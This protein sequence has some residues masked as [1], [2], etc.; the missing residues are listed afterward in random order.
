MNGQN[1]NER[2]GLENH[3]FSLDLISAAGEAGGGLEP[4]LHDL[5]IP[6]LGLSTVTVKRRVCLRRPRPSHS[7]PRL[8]I[9]AGLTKDLV[10]RR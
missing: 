9:P 1:T 8:R 7:F 4:I 6:S 5:A 2:Q 10:H 3:T